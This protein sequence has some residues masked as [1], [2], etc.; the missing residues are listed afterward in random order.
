[1]DQKLRE[2]ATKLLTACTKADTACMIVF[3]DTGDTARTTWNLPEPVD[4]E[5]L[6]YIS[7]NSEKFSEIAKACPALLVAPQV[8]SDDESIDVTRHPEKANN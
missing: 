4:P 1:M 8:S 5:I 2:L 6:E 7:L 3:V